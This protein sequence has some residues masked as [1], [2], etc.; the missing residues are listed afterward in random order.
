MTWKQLSKSNFE[1]LF[2]N[3]YETKTIGELRFYNL[4]FLFARATFIQ[5]IFNLIFYLSIYWQ[6]LKHSV[7]FSRRNIILKS[8]SERKPTTPDPL[9]FK[10]APCF[11]LILLHQSLSNPNMKSDLIVNLAE[12][13][14]FLSAL[15]PEFLLAFR[16]ET[17]TR[18]ISKRPHTK[19][20]KYLKQNVWFK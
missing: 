17:R 4:V 1:C 7:A 12:G 10:K 3:K 11:C 15:P 16:D 6:W 14:F 20:E 18:H 19:P 5:I 8:V 13:W 9:S 2:R